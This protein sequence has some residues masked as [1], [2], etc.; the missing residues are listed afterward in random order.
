MAT[1]LVL[2]LS[3]YWFSNHLPHRLQPCP[4]RMSFTNF[5]TLAFCFLLLLLC[6]SAAVS[7]IA[8]VSQTPHTKKWKIFRYCFLFCFPG[9]LRLSRQHCQVCSCWR[10]EKWSAVHWLFISE[11]LLFIFDNLFS[12]FGHEM[13]QKNTTMWLSQVRIKTWQLC[14]HHICGMHEVKNSTADLPFT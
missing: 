8:E 3:F 9:Q 12:L 14:L 6:R 13:L 11:L 2:Q 4:L 7:C 1:V 5:Y 10:L